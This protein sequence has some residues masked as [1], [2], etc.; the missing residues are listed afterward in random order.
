MTDSTWIALRV[1]GSLRG[2]AGDIAAHTS[3]VQVLVGDQPIFSQPDALS[4]L[5]QIEGSL[6]Y[7]DTLAPRPEAQRFKLLRASLEAAHNRLHTR[8]H[9]QGMMH[10]HTPAQE[11]HE[12]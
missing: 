10:R 4:V 1:R 9:Q 11:H 3:A 2:R 6:A 5:E 7:I 12:T 8:L